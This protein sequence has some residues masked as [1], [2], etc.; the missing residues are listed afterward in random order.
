MEFLEVSNIVAIW[1]L[2]WWRMGCLTRLSTTLIFN[3]LAGFGTSFSK[4]SQHMVGTA[5]RVSGCT[6]SDALFCLNHKIPQAHCKKLQTHFQSIST[7]YS[8]L[9]WL[10]KKRDV[11]LT[12]YWIWPNRKQQSIPIS[13]STCSAEGSNNL[14]KKQNVTQPLCMAHSAHRHEPNQFCIEVDVTAD[15]SA[16]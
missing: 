16:K 4:P 6:G 9:S 10:K 14:K 13:Y 1:T 5:H 11:A 8:G 3:S 2:D 12:W 7:C 15:C